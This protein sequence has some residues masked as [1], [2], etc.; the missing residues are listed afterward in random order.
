MT[1]K[2]KKLPSEPIE[3]PEGF[4]DSKHSCFAFGHDTHKDDYKVLRVVTFDDGDQ[5][6][7]EFEVKVYTWK[8][9]EGQWPKKN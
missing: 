3:K 7:K 1:R 4:V 9:I 6:L 5:R 2:F 8:K